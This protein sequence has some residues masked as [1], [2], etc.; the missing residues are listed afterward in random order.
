MKAPPQVWDK[1]YT[2]NMLERTI[3]EI[4]RRTK[5]IESF[6]TPE[7]LEKLVYLLVRELNERWKKRRIKGF[8]YW[9]MQE[10]RKN[11]FLTQNS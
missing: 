3:K 10:E 8:S 2:T 6:P 11:E 5:T 4:K 7:S 9:F 1:L